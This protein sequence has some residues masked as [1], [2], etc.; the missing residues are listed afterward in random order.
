MPDADFVLFTVIELVDGRRVG[1]GLHQFRL[2]PRLDEFISMNVDYRAKI[3]KVVAVIH[4]LVP[5]ATA[6]DIIVEYLGAESE[7][8]N[9]LFG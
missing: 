3:Y 9:I 5:I 8:D 4:P 6:G 1:L 7:L 2:V